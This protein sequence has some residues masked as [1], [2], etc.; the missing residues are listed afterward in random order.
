MP[1]LLVIRPTGMGD[2]L[3]GLP[4]LRALRRGFPGH[5]L[6]T[7]CPPD[8]VPLARLAGVADRFVSGPAVTGGAADPS[9]H[10]GRNAAILDEVFAE[11]PRGGAETIVVLK[12]PEADLSRRALARRPGQL[13]GFGHPDVE[14]TAGLPPYRPDDHILDRWARLLA[15]AGITPDPADLYLALPWEAPGTQPD[16]D[17]VPVGPGCAAPGPAAPTVLHLGAGSPSRRWPA[18]RWAATA[19]GLAA[20]GHAVVLTGSGAE[21][22]LAA[23]V[24]AQ[25][26]L[27]D[28]VN[29]AG[30]T[31]VV[32]L[33]RLVRS[34]RLVV[35]TDT[36]VPHLATV[37]ARPSVTIFG[38]TSPRQWGPPPG[39]QGHRV[40]WAG[41][42]GLEYGPQPDPGLLLI[43]AEQVLGAARDLAAVRDPDA[44]DLDARIAPVTR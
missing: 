22:E 1:T 9:L 24:A 2:L 44:Q 11:P 19:A 42:I 39:S 17:P 41:R 3:M 23:G 31:D 29:L 15:P 25:A 38:P 14:A 28:Q 20:D 10:R 12:M 36:G 7:T 35:S 43:G 4:A 5:R 34:A 13:L 6:V 8:L 37:F 21:R 16:A 40:L 18:Q 30:R 26:G 27:N 33:A 32:A